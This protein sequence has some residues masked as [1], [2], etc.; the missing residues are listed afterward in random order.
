MCETNKVLQDLITSYV[1]FAN[2]ILSQPSADS[3]FQKEPCP[4]DSWQK[5]LTACP[6]GRRSVFFFPISDVLQQ[7]RFDHIGKITVLQLA[8]F[9][10]FFRKVLVETYAIGSLFNSHII[11]LN[12]LYPVAT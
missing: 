3:S 10:D 7:N 5:Q 9:P 12:K 6:F 1:R 8:I 4:T 11:T 2:A